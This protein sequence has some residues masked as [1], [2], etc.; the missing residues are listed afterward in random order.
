MSGA[1]W[2]ISLPS[3]APPPDHRSMAVNGG[4]ERWPMTVSG[5]GQRWPTIVND[6]GTPL[7]ITG[8]MVNNR[9]VGG[10]FDY[11]QGLSVVLP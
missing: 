4:G 1:T 9:G 3:L 11:L 10:V 2:L 5:G 6:G 7:T 8:S